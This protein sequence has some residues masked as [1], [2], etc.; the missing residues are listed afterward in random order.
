MPQIPNIIPDRLTEEHEM[1]YNIVCDVKRKLSYTTDT[2]VNL[3][4]T[5]LTQLNRTDMTVPLYSIENNRWTDRD[6]MDQCRTIW[7]FLSE[8]AVEDPAEIDDIR[9][10]INGRSCVF[11]TEGYNESDVLRTLESTMQQDNTVFVCND[12]G[13]ARLFFDMTGSAAY[14]EIRFEEGITYNTLVICFAHLY[15]TSDLARVITDF[16]SKIHSN[17]LKRIF[18]FG[19]IDMTH[20]GKNANAFREIVKSNSFDTFHVG[21]KTKTHCDYR[22]DGLNRFMTSLNVESNVSKLDLN[23]S[24][25]ICDHSKFKELYTELKRSSPEEF[26]IVCEDREYIRD[27]SKSIRIP[28]GGECPVPHPNRWMTSRPAI[29]IGDKV[30]DIECDKMDYVTGIWEKTDNV[31]VNVQIGNQNNMNHSIR[32]HFGIKENHF[33][34]CGQVHRGIRMMTRHDVEWADIQHV[35]DN[36]IVSVPHM[37]V[38]ITKFTTVDTLTNVCKMATSKITLVATYAEIQ[39]VLS[40]QKKNMDDTSVLRNVKKNRLSDS[41]LLSV[42]Q[43]PWTRP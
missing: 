4:D 14:P 27:A 2:T 17:G 32:L 25:A 1:I 42:N 40:R 24:V 13:S 39:S 5:Q 15:G 6:T 30:K 18:I 8:F 36:G 20:V 19:D 29:R 38:I 26:H 16:K 35:R 7:E 9:D 41:D 37:I 23:D 3:Y 43:V 22:T 21:H 11:L 10:V 34:C 28:N 31:A 12:S 33:E